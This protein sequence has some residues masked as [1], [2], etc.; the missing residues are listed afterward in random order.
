MRGGRNQLDY[1]PFRQQPLGGGTPPKLEP[2]APASQSCAAA[3]NRDKFI[4]GRRVLG[5]GGPFRRR[6]TILI[7]APSL[8]QGISC[9]MSEKPE[10]TAE[11]KDAEAEVE[12]FREDLGPFVV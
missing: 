11:Q 10:K 3:T 12:G 6:R 7:S 1:Q 5:D 8:V 4:A 2:G 9:E